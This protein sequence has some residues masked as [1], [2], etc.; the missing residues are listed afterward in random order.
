MIDSNNYNEYI[1]RFLDGETTLAEE[2]ELYEWFGHTELPP[3]AEK[4]KEMFVWYDSLAPEAEPAPAA[5]PVRML[6]LSRLQWLSVAAMAAIL[7]ALGVWL[8]PADRVAPEYQAYEG[9]YIMRDGEKITDL[10]IVVPEIQRVE[11]D[12]NRHLAAMDSRIDG[13]DEEVDAMLT[14]TIET[15]SPQIREIINSSL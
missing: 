13:Y 8:R 5:T 3:G 1:R 15:E 4:W 9:S 2:R 10:A 14:R 12:I 6:P 11:A 7:F